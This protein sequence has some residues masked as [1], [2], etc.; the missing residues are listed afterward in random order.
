M[1]LFKVVISH[2]RIESWQLRSLDT[3]Y[4][5]RNFIELFLLTFKRLAFHIFN[6]KIFYLEMQLPVYHDIFNC[7]QY[8]YTTL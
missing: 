6:N 7:S 5:K 8:C 1:V 4:G 3:A 2:S